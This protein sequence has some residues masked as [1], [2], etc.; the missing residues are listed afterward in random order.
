MSKFLTLDGLSYFYSVLKTKFVAQVTGKGLSTNDYT[1]TEQTKLAGIATGA[2]NYSLP[3]A[4][5]TVLGG[6]KIGSNISID[7]SSALSVTKANA[8]AALG[9]TPAPTTEV[10]TSAGGLMSATDKTKLNGVATGAQVNVLEGVS[11][12]GAALTITSK[13]VNIDLS[14]YAKTTDLSTV[15]KYKGVVETYAKLPTTGQTIGDVYNITNTDS[16]NNIKA[17]DNVAWNG[18]SWDNLSGIVDLS[19]YATK[20]ELTAISSTIDTVANSDIDTIMA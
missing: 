4:S 3:N 13:G 12:N 19:G 8:I 15:L 9:F 16:T 17:G 1:T 10:T 14:A 6:V 7:S 18:T 5:S 2:N 20:A 11:V